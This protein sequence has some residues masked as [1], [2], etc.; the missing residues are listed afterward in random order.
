MNLNE[1]KRHPY[2]P[3]L[4]FET[5]ALS[6]LLL[7]LYWA[8]LFR[9]VVT[10]SGTRPPPS[11]WLSW[12][13][14]YFPDGNPIFH[15]IDRS[16]TPPR[17]LRIIQRF[18]ERNLQ[19]FDYENPVLIRYKAGAYVPFVPDL[20][21]GSTDEDAVTPIE[22]LLISSEITPACER[23]N[24]EFIAM[25]CVE[26]VSVEAMQQQLKVYWDFVGPY[27][28]DERVFEDEE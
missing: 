9:D 12:F 3:F 11:N 4:D 25:W 1:L 23:L 5:N 15:V 24:R 8:E 20:T 2:Y 26:R 14:A 7:E 6:F 10:A 16:C 13:P 27:L 21:Y 28:I 18:N 17:T 22:E 19:A